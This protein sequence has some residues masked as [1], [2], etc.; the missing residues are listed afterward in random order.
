MSFWNGVLWG[1]GFGER[2]RIKFECPF[3]SSPIKPKDE[4]CPNCGK[5]LPRCPNCGNVLLDFDECPICGEELW[6]QK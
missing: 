1:M 5:K 2:K 6:M 4:F 3:C